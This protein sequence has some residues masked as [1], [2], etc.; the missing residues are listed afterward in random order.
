MIKL[1][2]KNR[3]TIKFFKNL[4]NTMIPENK[5]NKL[6]KLSDATNVKDL[7]KVIFLNRD[8]KTKLKKKLIKIFSNHKRNKN[9]DYSILGKEIAESKEIE[10]LIEHYLLQAY[11][12][13]TIVKKKLSQVAH[14]H[15]LGNK[16]KRENISSLVGKIKNSKI[17]YKK[18]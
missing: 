10:N 4:F 9:I 6:P 11:F 13:S 16:I 1:E 2:Y 3:N 5:D 7:L 14:T 18:I 12:T 8:L 15:L 17:R